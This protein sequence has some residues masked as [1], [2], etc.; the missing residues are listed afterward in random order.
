MNINKPVV[1]LAA[2][3]ALTAASASAFAH[4]AEY[5]RGYDEYSSKTRNMAYAARRA[6]RAGPCAMK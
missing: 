4:S 6:M 1:R 5:R 2:I 3:L